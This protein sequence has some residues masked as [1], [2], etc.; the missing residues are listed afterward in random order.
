MKGLPTS[1]EVVEVQPLQISDH[2]CLKLA[3]L[4]VESAHLMPIIARQDDHEFLTT[5]AQMFGLQG[6]AQTA[7]YILFGYCD[8][9]SSLESSLNAME[10]GI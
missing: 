8:G 7:R 10:R 5:W 1:E 4:L 6:E 3:R 2:A 9:L